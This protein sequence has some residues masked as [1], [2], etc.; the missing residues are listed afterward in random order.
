MDEPRIVPLACLWN[1]CALFPSGL[2]CHKFCLT[3]ASRSGTESKETL[4]HGI[5]L[6]A[7]Q[8]GTIHTRYLVSWIKLDKMYLPLWLYK[9]PLKISWGSS[10]RTHILKCQLRALLLAKNIRNSW[11]LLLEP[12]Y[13]TQCWTCCGFPQLILGSRHKAYLQLLI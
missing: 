1:Q 9:M 10:A 12:G 5:W 2:L 6:A 13:Q 7:E 4:L 3:T 8:K 11:F